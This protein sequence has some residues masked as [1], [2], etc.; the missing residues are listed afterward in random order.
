MFRI[1][2]PSHSRPRYPIRL[3]AE[4][5][6]RTG[7]STIVVEDRPGGVTVIGTEAIERA[8]PYGRTLLLVA[9]SF[10]INPA[11]KRANYD[12]A[13]NFEPVCYLAATPM[14]LV[15]LGSSP[16]RPLD[17]LLTAARGKPGELAFASGGPGSSLHIAIEV[18]KRAA[19]INV[20]Y[21]PFGGTAPADRPATAFLQELAQL[22]WIAGLNVQI[23]AVGRRATPS[24]FANTRQNSSRL[25]QM[26]FLPGQSGG[27][28][29]DP[30]RSDRFETVAD[31]VGAGFVE[32]A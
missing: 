17:E 21:V 11:L 27:R 5:I 1:D 24:A 16:Y 4:Q 25:R 6:G 12:P 14:V 23:D 18:L 10:V 22:G 7:G 30:R 19:H 32:R 2:W 15:V 29:A 26:L 20:T 8:E 9:S 31:P 28:G 3:M 13:R